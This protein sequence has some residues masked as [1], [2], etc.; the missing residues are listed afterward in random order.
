MGCY[1]AQAVQNAKFVKVEVFTRPR[2]SDLIPRCVSKGT[3]CTVRGLGRKSGT[4]GAQETAIL[5]RDKEGELATTV[6]K[7]REKTRH[8]LLAGG[9]CYN[10]EARRWRN[11]AL[12]SHGDGGGD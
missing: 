2:R 8:D 9:V 1:T 7:G 12:D 5:G 10:A 11:S 6:D 3:G 4:G